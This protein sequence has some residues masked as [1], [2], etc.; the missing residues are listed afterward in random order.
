MAPFVKITP[1]SMKFVDELRKRATSFRNAQIAARIQVPSDLSWWYFLEY[2]T[3]S[4]QDA[5]APYR[6]SG[7]KY[8]IDPIDRGDSSANLD[9]LKFPGKDGESIYRAHVEH[10]GIRPHPFVRTTL[11]AIRQFAKQDL[12]MALKG[13]GGMRAGNLKLQLL[14]NTMPR[15]IEMIGETL[16][17]V[18]PGTRDDGKLQGNT[19]A[20]EWLDEEDGAYVVDA[21]VSSPGGA[22]TKTGNA[23]VIVSTSPKTKRVTIRTG[24]ESN[25][26]TGKKRL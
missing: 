5:S 4:R 22:S 11:P 26:P 23:A 1:K 16:A 10:P 13:A 6:G 24:H 20:E 17:T 15:A 14:N 18:A 25:I 19:A 2:G 21:S 8:P 3:A 9:M 12:I 7:E